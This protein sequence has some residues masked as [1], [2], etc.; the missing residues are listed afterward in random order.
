MPEVYGLH[1]GEVSQYGF[2][3]PAANLPV[4]VGRDR[5]STTPFVSE[6][7]QHLRS[8]ILYM[9]CMVTTPILACVLSK[10]TTRE[11]I[12]FGHSKHESSLQLIAEGRQTHS[13]RQQCSADY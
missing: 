13:R 10:R 3:R 8:P 1:F 5:V 6:L 11:I 2:L 7:L 9:E 12:T 4:N